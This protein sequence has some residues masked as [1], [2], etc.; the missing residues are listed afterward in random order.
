MRFKWISS[1]TAA[2]LGKV[3]LQCFLLITPKI[4]E[5]KLEHT[6]PVI[7]LADSTCMVGDKIGAPLSSDFEGHTNKFN[8]KISWVRL[9]AGL[10]ESERLVNPE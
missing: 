1:M 4:A 8:G 6:V 10:E 7:F 2:D 9:E 3:E 5:G